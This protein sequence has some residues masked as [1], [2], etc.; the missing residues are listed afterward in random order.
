MESPDIFFLGVESYELTYQATPNPLFEEVPGY[1]EFGD[2]A[3]TNA[4]DELADTLGSSY[5]FAMAGDDVVDGGDGDDAIYGGSGDDVIRGGDGQDLLDGG[6]GSDV[7]IGGEGIDIFVF[8]KGEGLTDIADFELSY[9]I[10]DVEGFGGQL[11]YEALT[12][13]GQQVG[14]D[15]VYT[16][17]DDTLIL[18]D[19]ELETMVE[20][21]LCIK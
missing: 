10:L 6:A 2:L 19:V 7:L 18:R 14:D 4:G 17:G 15:V 11:T 8:R 21:D 1:N 5:I 12:N 13:S 9:D 20:I 3:G 16:L